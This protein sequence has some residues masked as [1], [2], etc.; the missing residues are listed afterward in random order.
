MGKKV[1]LVYEE[2]VGIP[3]SCFGETG[4]YIKDIQIVE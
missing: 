1:V 2:H 4:Y 3:S